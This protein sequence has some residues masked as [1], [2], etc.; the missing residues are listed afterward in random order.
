MVHGVHEDTDAPYLD[1]RSR[2]E[3]DAADV[4]EPCKIKDLYEKSSH[5]N[6]GKPNTIELGDR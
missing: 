4:H 2:V 5:L 6:K 3:E 1:R